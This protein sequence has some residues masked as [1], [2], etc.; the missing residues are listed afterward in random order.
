MTR[1]YLNPQKV[2]KRLARRDVKVSISSATPSKY[3]LRPQCPVPYDQGNL[4]SCT[5]NAFCAAYK[6]LTKNQ[7]SP[8]RLYLY[9]YE[10]MLEDP[11]HNPLHLTDSGADVIDGE[12]Y[13]ANIGIC[14][15]SLWPYKIEKF[16][17]KP[18][19][20][21]DLDA[22]KHKIK[23]FSVI[24]I[25]ANLINSIKSYIFKGIPV[26]IAINVY[27]SFESLQTSRTGVVTLPKPLRYN[28]PRDPRDPYLGGHEMCIIGY[29]DTTSR[30]TVLNSWGS[31]WGDGGYC[32]IPYSYL[33]N[34]Y[35]G[36]EFTVIQV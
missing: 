10:R 14:S 18:P 23:S 13:A 5:A 30:V 12:K 32:Y 3:S 6:I 4:G 9:Y 2:S 15:E 28:N 8:S 36:L 33:T 20:Y 22:A 1:T 17:V 21:C 16:N 25:N 31:N 27:Q 24:P 11:T 26:L 19:T 34:P 35:L 7:F 29:D